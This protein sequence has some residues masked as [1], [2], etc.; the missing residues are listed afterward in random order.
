MIMR[1]TGR[2]LATLVGMLFLLPASAVLADGFSGGIGDT[3]GPRFKADPNRAPRGPIDLRRRP[4]PL[5]DAAGLVQRWNQIAIDATGLDHTPV[6]QPPAPGDNRPNY[7]EQ[8]GPG[9]SSRAMAIVHLAMFDALNAIEGEYKGYTGVRP[10]PFGTSMKAAIAQAA[11]DTLV[12]LFP[13]QTQN[14]DEELADDLTE[15]PDGRLKTNGVALGRQTAA[16]ILAARASD[17]S[18][19]PE[20]QV[21]IGPGNFVTS[22]DPGKWRQDPISTIPLAL[23]AYW[24]NVKPFVL[25]RGDQ[26]RVPPPPALDSQEYA[27]AFDEVKALGGEG[28]GS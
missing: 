25:E 1:Q 24:G 3:F 27:V 22:N 14:F 21:G 20:L 12:A 7:A 26:F 15:I 18:Q 19:H 28:R 2:F 6:S 4:R 5:V 8:L 13:A 10:A 16:A 11:H 9:R 17:G 23:G